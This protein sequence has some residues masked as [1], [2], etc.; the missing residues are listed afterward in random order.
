MKDFE[1][2]LLKRWLKRKVK[3]TL[4]ILVTFLVGGISGY[5]FDVEEIVIGKDLSGNYNLING[6]TVIEDEQNFM[7]EKN[8]FINNENVKS[9][10][11]QG[12]FN[13][14]VTISD[15]IKKEDDFNFINNGD[16]IG[17]TYLGLANQGY[18]K[19][20]LNNGYIYGKEQGIGNVYTSTGENYIELIDNKGIIASDKISLYLYKSIGDIKNS[21]IIKESL[22]MYE[23]ANNIY[24]NGKIIK[25]VSDSNG[26]LSLNNGSRNEV[27]NK[28]ILVAPKK[29]IH[30]SGGLKEVTNEGVIEKTTNDISGAIELSNYTGILKNSGV[31]NGKTKSISELTFN[32]E[33]VE[34]K[35]YG[36]VVSPFETGTGRG[37]RQQQ[38]F[39][40]LGLL[41]NE[42]GQLLKHKFSN[43]TSTSYKN[44]L[45]I[46]KN[47][48]EQ[49]INNNE[50]IDITVGE[51]GG[52]D[53]TV[54]IKNESGKTIINAG[55]DENGYV[56]NIKSDTIKNLSDTEGYILNGYDKTV[57]IN[58][59][60]GDKNINNSIINAVKTAVYIEGEN[61][62]GL[63]DTIVNGGYGENIIL[64][65]NNKNTL[66]LSGTT[67]INGNINLGAGDDSLSI[68]N[69]VQLNGI[70]DG[71]NEDDTL[72][73]NSSTLQE[74]NINVLH[75]IKGFENTNIN[76]DVTLFEKT[77]A[78][79]GDV[80]NLEVQ[81]GNITVGENGNLNLRI[82]GTEKDG[83]GNV[84]GHALYNNIGSIKVNGGKLNLKT[85][86]FGEEEII[87][88]NR[89]DITKLTSDDITIS[90]ILHESEINED[91]TISITAKKDLEDMDITN[92]EKLNKI[93]HSIIGTNLKEFNVTEEQYGA[94]LKY[95]TDIYAGTPY[96]FSSELSRKSVNMFSDVVMGRDL[97]P[98]VNKWAI[99]GGL[100]HIDGGTKDTYFGKGYYTYDIESKDIDVDS[101]I[102]GMYVQGEYGVNE[103]LNLGIIFGGNQS[104][105]EI[106]NSSKVEGDSFY[107][108]AYAKKYL[109]NLRLLA[110][111][112]YQY[113]D[114]EVDRVAVGYDGITTTRIFDSNYNDNT[115]N[116]YAQ[117][118]YSNKLAENLYLEPSVALD[119]T[120]VNQE[121]ASENGVLAIET[122][123]K[124]FNYTTAKFG[125]DLR[126]DIPTTIA[127][128]SLI[129]GAYYNRMLDGYEEENITGKFVGGSDF[130]ILVSP[131]NKHEVGLRAK[132]EVSLNNGVTFDVKGSYTFEREG[133]SRENKNEHKGEWIVGAGIGYRF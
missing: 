70:L 112:G 13:G 9:D 113:G 125:V 4:A 88:F 59:N 61:T 129:A 50:N 77:V 76:T 68:D 53:K 2:K 37:P 80:K 71:G 114:Y 107:L 16:I 26:G 84:I 1:E 79:N 72:T 44:E 63:K 25:T 81:L 128:H 86:G 94:F 123:S 54:Q 58:S 45:E 73:F 101:K 42:N 5:S 130:D 52:T 87:A 23:K 74:N 22:I 40:N 34:I 75:D 38:C 117:A 108:G 27:I 67:I 65:D 11:K 18:I 92:Y 31:I 55:S 36:I 124:D 39:E 120:Y 131:S 17:N 118:K 62:L 93:Y 105:S 46:A 104:E 102:T 116:I 47:V 21:G 19:T 6:G 64:G 100:T 49:V 12:Y 14:V 109:G 57:V 97:H 20:L 10:V 90:S 29:V 83:E 115:F 91:N 110:G 127:T 95:I 132:Y 51:E 121:G 106:N 24:N 85:F 60:T 69:T 99:Y 82:D 8:N 133:Y 96:S 43:I 56:Q 15:K 89:T 3:I 33:N 103:T 41:I 119:Y 126:K 111:I 98:E 32:K 48:S 7:I 66:N 30:N 122:D 35:N 78:E 28:G